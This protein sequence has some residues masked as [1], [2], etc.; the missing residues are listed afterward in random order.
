M[1][2]LAKLPFFSRNGNII[3]K[4][5]ICSDGS[6]CI[7]DIYQ[8]AS[9]TTPR[10]MN[11]TSLQIYLMGSSKML[12]SG[13]TFQYLLA[14][15]ET[16]DSRSARIDD[17]RYLR[18]VILYDYLFSDCDAYSIDLEGKYICPISTV[19]ANCKVCDQ[20]HYHFTHSLIGQSGQPKYFRRITPQI[21]PNWQPLKNCPSTDLCLLPNCFCSK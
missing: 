2:P 21:I 20:H 14:S 3:V 16:L 6:T 10:K 4:D 19:A 17:S 12:D 5:I 18:S 8:Y 15:S 9:D 7:T 13:F 11:C 1:I